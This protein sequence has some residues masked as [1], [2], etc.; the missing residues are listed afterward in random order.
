M[1]IFRVARPII[2]LREISYRNYYV[3]TYPL[4]PGQICIL[5]VTS[6]HFQL[7]SLTHT[8]H[9][10]KSYRRVFVIY[11]NRSFFSG[12]ET[13]QDSNTGHTYRIINTY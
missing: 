5:N 8:Y 12:I 2:F 6:T 3:L 7:H 11:N 1:S 9:F 13:T 10:T 4:K